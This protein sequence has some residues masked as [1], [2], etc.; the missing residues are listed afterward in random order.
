LALRISRRTSFLAGG[1]SKSFS[2]RESGFTGAFLVPLILDV[3]LLVSTALDVH[4]HRPEIAIAD[5]DANAMRLSNRD[6]FLAQ[7]TPTGFSR[8]DVRGFA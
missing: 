2:S 4:P 5:A 7:R 1:V 3:P 6:L 8:S